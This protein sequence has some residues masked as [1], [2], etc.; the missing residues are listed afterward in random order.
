MI[1]LRSTPDAYESFRST[2]DSAL[3][4]PDIERRTL[5]AIPPSVEL[6]SDEQGRVYLAVSPGV[7]PVEILASAVFAGDV[8]EVSEDV[9]R[10]AFA[11]FLGDAATP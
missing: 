4:Y 7:I 11:R 9:F 8:E 1:C 10:A 2:L 5:T 3:G 6:P